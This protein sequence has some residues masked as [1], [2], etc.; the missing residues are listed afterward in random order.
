MELQSG[1]SSVGSFIGWFLVLVSLPIAPA[2]P[3]HA[4][5][6]HLSFLFSA[7]GSHTFA[8]MLVKYALQFDSFLVHMCRGTLPA[9]STKCQVFMLFAYLLPKKQLSVS[10]VLVFCRGGICVYG[11]IKN[12]EDQPS[13]KAS[14]FDSVYHGFES[15]IL[16]QQ[17]PER[18][19][20]KLQMWLKAL[21]GFP[22]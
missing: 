11:D 19:P 5:V 2:P 7:K 15:H 9:P 16:S 3:L 12:A 17:K 18:S 4:N 1:G 14:D 10:T 8:N 6:F 22:D 20:N 13:G 21:S